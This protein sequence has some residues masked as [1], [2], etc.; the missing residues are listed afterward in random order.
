MIKLIF[1]TSSLELRNC[2][3]YVRPSVRPRS[4]TLANSN[5]KLCTMIKN[6]KWTKLTASDFWNKIW[7]SRSGVITVEKCWKMDSFRIFL[8]TVLRILLIFEIYMKQ[9]IL[10]QIQAFPF[11]GKI[12][13]MSYGVILN[14]PDSEYW[15]LRIILEMVR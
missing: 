11:F 6:H 13:I 5:Q 14:D 3:S 15:I 8:K 12:W 2:F 4:L 1:S 10:F 7:N 9:T